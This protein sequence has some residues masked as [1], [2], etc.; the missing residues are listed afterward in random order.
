MKKR[1]FIVVPYYQE[2]KLWRVCSTTSKM[3]FFNA[4]Q[5]DEYEEEKD[6]DNEPDALE[7]ARKKCGRANII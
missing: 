3:T 6:F 7:F 2:D 1:W 4:Y 5:L